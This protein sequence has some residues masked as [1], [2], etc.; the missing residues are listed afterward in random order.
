MKR[1]NVT[2]LNR[3]LQSQ[4]MLSRPAVTQTHWHDW[5]QNVSFVN[6]LREAGHLIS[7]ISEFI[8][9]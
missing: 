2:F 9:F 8:L 7:F 1:D 5:Q 6:D 4:E 3:N